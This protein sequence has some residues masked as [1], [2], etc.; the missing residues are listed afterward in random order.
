MVAGVY[1]DARQVES[2]AG[3]LDP[4]FADTES[5]DEARPA[6]GLPDPV[7]DVPERVSEETGPG[8]AKRF[9]I[10][11]RALDF[12]LPLGIARRNEAAVRARV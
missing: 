5:G 6:D 12:F 2:V 9:D 8:Q 11:N 3:T 7:V 4:A 1:D 10:V